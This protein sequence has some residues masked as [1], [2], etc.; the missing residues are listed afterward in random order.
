[1]KLKRVAIIAL[2]ALVLTCGGFAARTLTSNA[3]TYDQALAAASE[4]VPA[5]AELVNS[6]KDWSKYEFDYRDDTASADYE[7]EVSKKKKMVTEV[8]MEYDGESGGNEAKLDEK[9]ATAIAQEQFPDASIDQIELEQDDSGYTYEIG[10]FGNGYYGNL[11]INAETGA[12]NEYTLHYG[13]ATMIP[14]D[15]KNSKDDKV[16]DQSS[17]NE[18]TDAIISE[19]EAKA[20]VLSEVPGAVI[21]SVELEKDDGIPEYEITAHLDGIQYE[22][23]IHAVTGVITERDSESIEADDNDDWDDDSDDWDDDNDD[24]DDDDDD[25]DYAAPSKSNTKKAISDD[26]D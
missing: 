20:I 6:E 25:D 17:K 1:M 4:H 24:W 13:T 23:S 10:F 22:F 9:Q 5:S 26:D 3:M 8:S 21:D 15:D 14:L 16:E 19:E 18:K 11:E 12:V 7:V 2:A